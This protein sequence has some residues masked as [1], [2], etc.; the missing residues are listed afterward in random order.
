MEKPKFKFS[1]MVA[2]HDHLHVVSAVGE[3]TIAPKYVDVPGIGSIP[4]YSP[5]VT[6]TEPIMYNPPGDC[7]GNFMSY[8]FQPNNNCYNYSTNIATNSFAQPGRKHGTKITIDG[9]V[10][11]NAAIQ[12]GLIAIGNTTETKVSELKDL[13]PDNPGH[14]VALMISIPDHSVNWPGDYHWARCDDLANSKWSQKDGG[15]QVTNFD[16]AG[17]PISDPSTANWTV[18]QGPGMI[19]G[20]N[21]DVVVEYKFYTYMYSPYGKVDII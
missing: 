12:D 5:T 20:N 18:N 3:E 9:E 4:Q 6:G 21:D 1:G 8:R 14:F 7:D 10:V 17:N 2:D 13:T 16:F 15:D 19:Q 11:T